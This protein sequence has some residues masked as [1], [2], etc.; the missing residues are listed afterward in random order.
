[1]ASR[2]ISLR[3]GAGAVRF[4]YD[5]A[6]FTVLTPRDEG[7]PIS[8]ADLGYA[9]SAP[10]ESPPLEEIVDP[11]ERVLVVAP[12]ATRA[13]G[14]ERVVSL[15]VLRL[16]GLGVGDDEMSVLVGGGAHRPATPGE[17]DAIV[18]PAVAERLEVSAHDAADTRAM[19]LL[20]E[21]S[22]GTPVEVN[23]RLVEAD[24]VVV[25]GE[26]DFHYFAGFTGGRKAILPGCASARAVRA[27]HLLA[28]GEGATGRRPGV[29]PGRLD[30]NAVHEDMEEAARMLEPSFLVN[31]VV[32]PANEITRAYAGHWRHAHR[33]GC[34]EYADSHAVP[35]AARR[36]LAVVSCGGAPR[37]VNLIQAHKAMEHASKVLDDGGSMVV[38]AECA[39][40]LGRPDFLDWFVDGGAAATAARLARDYQVN[41]QTAWSLRSKAE[42]FRIL[43]VSTLEPAD[44]RRMGMEPYETLGSAVAAAG[45][46]PGYIIPSGVSTLPYVGP[47]ANAPS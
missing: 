47:V 29:G 17:M 32:G 36:P 6:D 5:P 9:L 45:G 46:G 40:G 31:T 38:L 16:S 43:L 19:V 24:H 42:R 15:L 41:G 34:A 8:G 30:G 12:D 20:G 10:I 11:G 25:T 33:R 35:V 18:G 3:Y 28:L 4:D 1:M 7:E 13:A 39:E 23:R 37:D 27:N 14:S 21:T 22:R 44:V 26:I 2:A